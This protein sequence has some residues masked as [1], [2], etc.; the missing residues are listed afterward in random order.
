MTG[1]QVQAERPADVLHDLDLGAMGVGE[2]DGLHSALDGDVD[3][4]PKGRPGVEEGPVPDDFT[5]HLA[6]VRAGQKRK[7]ILMRLLDR[8]GL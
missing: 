2:A 6:T 8:H 5:A 3:A 1:R 7:R 4:L